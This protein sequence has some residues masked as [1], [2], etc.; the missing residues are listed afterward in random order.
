MFAVMTTFLS[1]CNDTKRV[2]PTVISEERICLYKVITVL[3][4][5]HP[6][7]WKRKAIERTFLK[8]ANTCVLFDEAMSDFFKFYFL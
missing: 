2:H 3:Q 6:I 7:H 5:Q 4:K 8:S 1:L